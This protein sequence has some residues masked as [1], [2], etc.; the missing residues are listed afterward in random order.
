M[1]TEERAS[2]NKEAW[3]MTALAYRKA[4]GDL[5]DATETVRRIITAC[6]RIQEVEFQSL[7]A[8]AE[9]ALEAL[10]VAAHGF[11]AAEYVVCKSEETK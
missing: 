7:A 5:E 4:Q 6:N 3:P 9:T 1:K 11:N 2:A 8:L 10:E